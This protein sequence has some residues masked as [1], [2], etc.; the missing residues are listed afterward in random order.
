MSFFAND[1]RSLDAVADSSIDLV[2]SFDSLVH[3]DLDAMSGYVAELARVL[4]LE[5]VAFLHHSNLGAN[6]L[7][8]R[9]GKVPMLRG[10]LRQLGRLDASEHWRD[11]TVSAGEIAGLCDEAGLR[12]ISQELITWAD[13]TYPID[14]ISV[15]VRAD[16][17][18][19]RPTRT[20][21]N[22]EFAAHV[23]YFHRLAELYD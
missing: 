23:E 11:P 21:E 15:I 8:V 1:G 2:F 4:R 19:A 17:A 13:T 22:L 16:S 20:F 9:A 6:T 18:R 7:S 12:C 5:G 10:A 14:C 3:A